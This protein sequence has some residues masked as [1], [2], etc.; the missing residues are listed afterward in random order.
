MAVALPYFIKMAK[1]SDI[2]ITKFKYLFV[3]INQ[4][5]SKL[6]EP[7]EFKYKK[8][9]LSKSIISSIIKYKLPFVMNKI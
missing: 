4:K 1:R 9:T 2:Y 3:I 8:T 7:N 6:L 5:K